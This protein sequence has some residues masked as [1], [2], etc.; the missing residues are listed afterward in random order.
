MISNYKFTWGK[1]T[2]FK[3]LT[4]TCF[5]TPIEFDLLDNGDDGKKIKETIENVVLY[6]IDG[7]NTLS[8]R[9]AYEKKFDVTPLTDEIAN[10]IKSNI[11]E[12]FGIVV[13]NKDDTDNNDIFRK[14]NNY[15][16]S[17]YNK[18]NDNEAQKFRNLTKLRHFLRKYLV[19]AHIS[20]VIT[21]AVECKY[22][23]RKGNLEVEKNNEINLLKA[24]LKDSTKLL[25]NIDA[26]PVPTN[27]DLSRASSEDGDLFDGPKGPPRG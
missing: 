13:P 9:D 1:D 12:L 26:I 17:K 18:L 4:L 27:P 25:L 8:I 23:T 22:N 24:L 15:Y 3:T 19:M 5:N 20:V 2:E 10:K 14:A 21:K 6:E 11:K 16:L 7:R